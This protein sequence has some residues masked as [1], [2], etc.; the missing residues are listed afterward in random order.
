MLV[1]FILYIIQ[2]ILKTIFSIK[3]NGMKRSEINFEIKKAEKLLENMS[4]KLPPFGYWN[5]E[6]MRNAKN[7]IDCAEIFDCSL[8]W[9][10]C[11]FGKGDFTNYGLTLFTLRNGLICDSN[12]ESSKT[13]AEKLL[14]SNEKQITMMHFHYEKVEDIINRGGGNLVI[15]M[16][17]SMSD[18]TLDKNSPVVISCDGIKKV[19]QPG[20][21]IILKRGESI[22]M[23]T[24]L[25]HSFWAEE[26]YEPCLIQEV[27]KLNN[28]V[29][30]NRFLEKAERF[31]QIN[32]DE[33]PYRLLVSDYNNIG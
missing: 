16:Y 10:I 20:E 15:Q 33:T 3:R 2:E 31:P 1:K 30:D 6:E 11:D 29:I 18:E 17:N 4:I 28:D 9:D 13:Y 26:G 19:F 32:E 24:G 22:T 21:E 25:Y 23:P 12:N 8:G 5:K 7:N 14:F 27:S